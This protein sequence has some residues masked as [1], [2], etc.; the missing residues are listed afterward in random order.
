MSCW[1]RKVKEYAARANEIN[2]DALQMKLMHL[3]EMGRRFD[4]GDKELYSITKF[5][6]HIP[7]LNIQ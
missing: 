7:E 5:L 6:R 1:L 2:V 3:D 4:H